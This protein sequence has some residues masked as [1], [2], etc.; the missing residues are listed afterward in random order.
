[1]TDTSTYLA[2]AWATR[3]ARAPLA[4]LDIPRRAP[5]PR[6][7]QIEI[8]YCGICLDLHYTHDDWH[9]AL[10]AARTSAHNQ[11]LTFGSR[12]RHGTAP[13]TFGGYS[14]ASSSTSTSCCAYRRTWTPPA[15]R[16]CCAPASRP[17]RR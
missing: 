5:T 6:D 16:R 12:D 8:L 1:M 17:T 7:V 9:D 11:T 13:M 3:G 10:P 15:L 14:A 4:P 2:H